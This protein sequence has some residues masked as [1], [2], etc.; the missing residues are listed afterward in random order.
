[1]SL[2]P[3]N[4]IISFHTTI[5]KILWA[6]CE[7]RRKRGVHESHWKSLS[8]MVQ[9]RPKINWKLR[10]RTLIWL[11]RLLFSKKSTRVTGELQV[12]ID[13]WVKS[14]KESFDRLRRYEWDSRISLKLTQPN[15]DV[16]TTEIKSSEEYKN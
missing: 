12:G 15:M 16:L 7:R 3:V 14:R 13:I 2:E 10:S 5:K 6:E 9:V 8:L 11:V 4:I 1:M